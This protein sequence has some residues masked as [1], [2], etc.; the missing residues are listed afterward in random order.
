MET[1]YSRIIIA[2]KVGPIIERLFCTSFRRL[3]LFRVLGCSIRCGGIIDPFS[4]STS[5][6]LLSALAVM[7]FPRPVSPLSLEVHSSPAPNVDADDAW[8]SD[9]EL[10]DVARAAKRRRI[11][12][13]GEAYLQGSP[14][15]ILSAS[16]RG[17]FDRQWRNPWKKD[18]RRIAQRKRYGTKDSE[19][20]AVQETDY[21]RKLM[22][23]ARN[24][25]EDG[26]TN[27]ETT[28]SDRSKRS[29]AEPQHSACNE[30]FMAVGEFG[31]V[32]QR[33]SKKSTSHV[34]T[35]QCYT[36]VAK[37][38]HSNWLRKA[39]SRKGIFDL[40]PPSSPLAAVPT[41]HPNI[42]SL[43]KPEVLP[44]SSPRNTLQIPK[45][46]D[47]KRASCSSVHSQPCS[48]HNSAYKLPLPTKSTSSA[49][50]RSS[51]SS[52][53]VKPPSA[54]NQT[55]S[56]HVASSHSHLPKFEYRR[57]KDRLRAQEQCPEFPAVTNPS[58]ENVNE[59]YTVEKLGLSGSAT[60]KDSL[61]RNTEMNSKPTEHG[62]ISQGTRPKESRSVSFLGG[63]KYPS[64]MTKTT[65]ERLPSGQQ[66]PGKVNLADFVI[67]LHSTQAPGDNSN[68][69]E[70]TSPDAQ[71]S[72]QAAVLLAQKSFQNDL[73]SPEQNSVV[74]SGKK[75]PPCQPPCLRSSHLQTITPLSRVRDVGRTVDNDQLG[76][77]A[78][79]DSHIMSTQNMVDAATPFTFSTEKRANR[80]MGVL[81]NAVEPNSKRKR[82]N[83]NSQTSSAP[84]PLEGRPQSLARRERLEPTGSNSEAPK[85]DVPANSLVVPEQSVHDGN[86]ED[87]SQ[88]TALPLTLAGST[89]STAQVSQ[90]SLGSSNL[91]EAVADAGSWLRQSFDFTRELGACGDRNRPPSSTAAR[92]SGPIN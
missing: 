10:D 35:S 30:S 36:P 23:V 84:S 20:V 79:N 45:S 3:D 52:S 28:K 4:G 15:L 82:K 57:L 90:D 77:T 6:T 26:G 50:Q 83:P 56:V 51:H 43:R 58:E 33:E 64:N 72:T 17:P 81:S 40:D 89:P 11:E 49:R 42:N 85:P 80:D 53:P 18:R 31:R 22:N 41:R 65:S 76:T 14:L 55:S 25:Y 13:L 68:H 46:A 63:S 67:S 60:S 2:S 71:F 21:R 37:E 66:L 48:E 44:S 87:D 27:P 32:S 88:M 69:N 34:K 92:H 19:D 39:R 75:S 24:K 7:Q 9:D 1:V 5:D 86:A 8:C 62:S 29:T 38:K 73:V 74:A 61:A 78:E 47:E 16:L 59:S 54:P 12:K 70:D 91:R